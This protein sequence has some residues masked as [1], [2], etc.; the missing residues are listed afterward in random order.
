[1]DGR[2]P[3]DNF[4][5]PQGFATALVKRLPKLVALLPGRTWNAALSASNQGDLLTLLKR[6]L[7]TVVCNRTPRSTKS[8]LEHT[9]ATT[10]LL[11]M[12]DELSTAGALELIA[13]LA[14]DAP[15]SL[16]LL[17]ETFTLLLTAWRSVRAVDK[18]EGLQW[19]TLVID[20]ANL[21]MGWTDEHPAELSQLLEYLKQLTADKLCHVVIVVSSE[22][23][24]THW[25][26]DRKGKCYSAIM[27][28]IYCTFGIAASTQLSDDSIISS[29][30]SASVLLHASQCCTRY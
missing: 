14:W 17:F 2:S 5:S 12:L 29:L 16:Q 28:I 7:K 23:Q 20:Y 10:E 27:Y 1:V 19:P 25:P 15:F 22:H 26:Q 8:V 4:H 9:D 3:A 13:T 6:F 30:Y 21:L 18:P 11:Q 24:F